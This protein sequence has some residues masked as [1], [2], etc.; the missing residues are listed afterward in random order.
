M[1]SLRTE[2]NQLHAQVCQAL[3]SP[4]R[5]LIL[6]ALYES[7]SNVSALA[8]KLEI[9]QPNISRHLNV[10]KERRMVTRTRQGKS[11][12]YEI[13]DKRVIEALDL[14][15]LVLADGLDGQK[16]LADSVNQI[17]D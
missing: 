14:L 3:A 12:I 2:I 11:V 9:S 15:R 6:Y 7:P 5:I 16:E 10:L 13:K 1:N 17:I 8:D 4:T